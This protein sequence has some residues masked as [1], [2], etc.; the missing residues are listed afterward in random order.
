[1]KR[2]FIVNPNAGSENRVNYIK[3]LA[4]KCFPGEEYIIYST[5]GPLDAT[6][7]VRNICS[8]NSEEACFYACGGDGTLSEVANGAFGFSNAVI[9]CVPC[10]SG[11][12]FVKYFGGADLFLDPEQIKNSVIMP[13]DLMNIDGRYCINICNFGFDTVVADTMQK[14]KYKKV[15]GGKNAYYTGIAVALVKAMKTEC[16]ITVD[17]ELI[18]PKGKICL[19]TIGNGNY[20]GG[21]FCCA[22]RAVMNDGLLEVCMVA[23]ISR[24]RFPKLIKPYALGEHLDNPAFA[25]CLTYR[26]GKVIEVDAKEGFAYSH[27]GEI[28]HTT[29]F[30]A[31]VVPNAIKLM[32]P[33][34]S[35]RLKTQDEA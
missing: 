16:N 8:T 10:G 3:A 29:H 15:I 35:P 26:R 13:I 18:T 14:V 1:M 30:K 17:G 25:D 7:Y 9:A 27:D 28:V 12:D 11:N 22:P 34:A 24:F 6:E 4:E 5:K 23:P 19:C 20:V 33:S 21:S 32:V 2:Y 31:E